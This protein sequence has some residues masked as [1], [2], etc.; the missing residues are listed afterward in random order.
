VYCAAIEALEQQTVPCVGASLDRRCRH[1]FLAQ[2]NDASVKSLIC[3]V[4]ARVL[5]YDAN[6]KTKEI[7]Y[8]N[9]WEKGKLLNLT[10]DQAS[11][12]MGL[13]TFLDKHAKVDG[14]LD[15]SQNQKQFDNWIVNA[16]YES[17]ELPVL[18]C[19]EDR[20][21]DVEHKDCTLCTS[22]KVHVELT[23]SFI[24]IRTITLTLIEGACLH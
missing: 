12:V 2:F 4:C 1:Q 16:P 6:D 7:R 15:L 21:C 17:K 22:C 23:L 3:F 14:G 19:P 10:V 20:Q 8:K 13:E 9:V 11:Q 18:C 5:P 24:R